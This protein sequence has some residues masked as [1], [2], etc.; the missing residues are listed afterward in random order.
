MS[1]NFSSSLR[2][3]YK[4]NLFEIIIEKL[5]DCSKLMKSDCLL[6]DLKISNNEILIRNRL[7]EKYLDDDTIRAK[8]GI[9]ILC[10]RF[11]PEK[12]EGYDDNTDLY[13]GRTDISVVTQNWLENDRKDYYTIECKRI[14][15]NKEL[16][17]RYINEGIVRFL[18]TGGSVKYVSHH[19]KNIM[20]GF[21]VRNIN[22]NNNIIKIELMQ[23]E[24]LKDIL[25]SNM[26]VLNSNNDEYCSCRCEYE[27]NDDILELRHVFYNF[28]E[29]I[30]EKK[31]K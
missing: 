6:S 5:L 2:T 10:L 4:N 12:S 11:I 17:K 16:N 24:I 26:S 3:E 28:S 8:I 25:I 22:I 13:I 7:V 27:V 15:G 23:R 1:G 9:D 19:K 29:I 14:D 30:N 31:E 18:N 21:V 20:Y